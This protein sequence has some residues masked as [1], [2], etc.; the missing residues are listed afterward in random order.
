[1]AD[2]KDRLGDTLQKKERGEE[3]R[4]FAEQNRKNLEKL[5]EQRAALD[6]ERAAHSI[7]ACPR[8]GGEF[9][10]EKH[11]GVAIDRCTK[12]CGVW[13]DN[14]ELDLVTQRS[15]DGWLAKLFGV[16]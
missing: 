5:R 14:G 2:D 16:K 9:V 12:G 6:A 4:Y 1:M 8:C 15:K 13:L 11:Q 7:G 10:E 3:E